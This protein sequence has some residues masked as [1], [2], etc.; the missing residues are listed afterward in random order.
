[1]KALR[2][3]ARE[4]WD[5][6]TEV[7][8]ERHEAYVVVARKRLDYM[9]TLLGKAQQNRQ[10]IEGDV[11]MIELNLQKA[12]TDVAAALLRGQLEERRRELRRLDLETSGLM[13]RINE[14]EA[15]VS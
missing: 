8:K 10:R 9:H 4:L 11:A 14:A 13:Q 12:Q 1:M 3:R 6:A 5:R 2:V 15:A 7:S